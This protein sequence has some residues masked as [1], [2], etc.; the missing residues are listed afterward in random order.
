[1][2]LYCVDDGSKDGMEGMYGPTYLYTYMGK[3]K[4]TVLR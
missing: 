4:K 1:M 2:V 3:E